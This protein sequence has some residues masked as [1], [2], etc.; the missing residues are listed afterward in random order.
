MIKINIITRCTRPSNLRKIK[1]SIFRTK[2]FEIAWWVG[3]DT[4]ILKDIDADI[5]SEIQDSNTHILF[6][7]GIDGDFGHSII[8]TI[9]D[10]ISDGFIYI[11]DDDNILHEDFYEK[12]KSSIDLNP[13]KIGFIFSQRVDGKDW[14]GL[15]IRLASPENTKVQHIDMSQFLISR[16][17]ISDSRLESMNYKADGVFIEKLFNDNKDKFLFIQDILSYYNY[18]SDAKYSSSPRIIYIGQGNPELKTFRIADWESNDLN[19]L[20]RENDNNI[21]NDIIN[22]NPDAILT[23]GNWEQ[24]QQLGIQSS[25]IRKKW[26]NVS[27]VDGSSGE[28]IYQCAMHNILNMDKSDLI[29]YF[30]PAYNIG[31][32]ILTTYQSLKNQTYPN[33]EWIL[34]NDSTDGGKT[35][36]IIE[37][38]AE[39]D[40]RIKIYDFRKKSGGIVGE[41]K[42]RAAGLCNGEVIAELDH[43][44]Y[45]MPECTKMILDAST[46]YPDAGFFYTD[47]VEMDSNWNSP[48]FYGDGFAFGYGHYREE[49]HLGIKMNVAE[50]FNINPKTIRHIVGVP[51]HIRAWR[52]SE[53][54]K[55]GG[56]NRNLTIADDF[57]LVVRTFLST[58]MVRIPQLG[59]LQFIHE[60]GSNT[61][62][63]SR[64]DIQ[65]R[66]RTIG[67]YYN[68]KI[69][70][71]FSELG[72]ED[73]AY[74]ENPSSPLS[75]PSR[76][77]QQEGRSN[78]IFG[79]E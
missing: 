43:D 48:K 44:D 33:W 6:I 39:S 36:K 47:C 45:L 57:E 75:T 66:V 59:Y 19:I 56:Y 26:I 8:N 62:N 1:N 70:D 3:F 65:R 32:K 37:K 63:L 71:R 4:S 53:Y 72:I 67:E 25:E 74:L 46:K 34:V 21:V 68:K 61:H 79:E 60:S 55:I 54:L 31:S 50:S 52:R 30:T 77:G 58:K 7:N 38:L 11:L 12:I 14:S 2:E 10:K 69:F 5:L 15:Q 78:I 29:S 24:Y 41:S 22:F 18:L 20:Y 28:S 76:F 9:I 35:L 51:N 27:T 64:A 73:W 49:T 40:A 17:L 13:E 42:Y 16:D 23:T